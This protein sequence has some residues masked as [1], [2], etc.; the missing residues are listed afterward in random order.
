M[1]NVKYLPISNMAEVMP[2]LGSAQSQ[3]NPLMLTAYVLGQYVAANGQC[4]NL[5]EQIKTLTTTVYT[6]LSALQG[7]EQP[8]VLASDQVRSITPK[9]DVEETL[10]RR[11]QTMLCLED[12]KWYK[13]LTRPL[14]RLGITPHEYKKKWGLPEDY[15]H[16][17]AKRYINELDQQ[18]AS[19]GT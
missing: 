16:S 9:L 3:D 2:K 19:A 7:R 6:S 5:N 4:P 11:N 10:C 12:N 1:E 8:S 18:K 15:N 13:S 17:S 14:S